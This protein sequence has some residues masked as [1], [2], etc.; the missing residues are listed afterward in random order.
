MSITQTDAARL[1]PVW[2]WLKISEEEFNAKR[3]EM[4]GVLRC[5]KCKRQG[6]CVGNSMLCMYCHG[7]YRRKRAQ[8]IRSMS[9]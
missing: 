4:I 3:A 6:M 8:V 5:L 7:A 9:A 1:F 2:T